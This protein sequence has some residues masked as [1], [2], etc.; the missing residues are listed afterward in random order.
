MKWYHTCGS[1]PPVYHTWAQKEEQ[2]FPVLQHVLFGQFNSD[3]EDTNRE[4]DTGNFERHSVRCG[5]RSSSP[6]TRVEEAD[7]VG[8]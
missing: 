7:G 6:G 1:K 3:G 5:C 8:A 2:A 4:D